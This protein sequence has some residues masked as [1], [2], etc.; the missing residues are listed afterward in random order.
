MAILCSSDIGG[1]WSA[2][3]RESHDRMK[4]PD[5]RALPLQSGININSAM[6]FRLSTVRTISSGY[7]RRRRLP[8]PCTPP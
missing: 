2:I 5:H 8:Q 1:I 3:V 6:F 7:N 4:I